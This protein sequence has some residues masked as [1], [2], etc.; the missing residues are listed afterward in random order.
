MT[1]QMKQ[2]D[3]QR[4]QETIILNQTAIRPRCKACGFKIRGLNH[5]DGDHHKAGRPSKD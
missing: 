2:T 3:G 4:H 1:K 5:N